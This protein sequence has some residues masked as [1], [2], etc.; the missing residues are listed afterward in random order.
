[1]TIDDYTRIHGAYVCAQGDFC[2]NSQYSANKRSMMVYVYMMCVCMCPSR[3]TSVRGTRQESCAGCW[4]DVTR[5]S[6]GL[7]TSCVHVT[8]TTGYVARPHIKKYND[9]K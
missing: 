8:I 2:P 3:V 6:A 5:G 9:E 1:M 7:R 4:I